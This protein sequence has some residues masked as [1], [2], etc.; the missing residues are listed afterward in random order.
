[1]LVDGKH[2]SSEEGTLDSDK[3]GWF[4]ALLSPIFADSFSLEEDVF[5]TTA[6]VCYLKN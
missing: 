5:P 4:A 2:G 3:N 6:L 1:M